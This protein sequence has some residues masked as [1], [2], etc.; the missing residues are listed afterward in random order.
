M[1]LNFHLM[2][3]SLECH[4]IVKIKKKKNFEHPLWPLTHILT[5]LRNSKINNPNFYKHERK[6]NLNVFFE[7]V[8][9][10]I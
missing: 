8:Y 4:K 5:L 1:Y 2:T 6:S 10:R 3:N 7:L 9:V